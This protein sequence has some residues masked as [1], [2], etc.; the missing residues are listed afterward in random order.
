MARLAVGLLALILALSPSLAAG[1]LPPLIDRDLFFGNPEIS[2]AQLSPDGQFIAFIKPYEG[3][4]NVWVKRLAEPFTAAKLVTTD[5]RRPITNY[6][7]SRDS[8]Y[9][10]F[11]QDKAA[12]R[13]STSTPSIR[14]PRPTRRPASR[15]PRNLTDAK[16][17]RAFIYSLPK[18]KPRRDLRRPERSRSGLARPL[19]GDDLDRRADAAAEEHREDRRLGVRRGRDAA[20]R[21]ARRRQR[22]HRDPPRRRGRLHE[23]LFVQRLRDRA[24]RC[25]STRTAAASTW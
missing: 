15:R 23:G 25:A 12:T 2:G 9:M 5:P 16:G 19:P 4:R 8:K 10:L 17:A 3:T 24:A 18:T 7:W 22:R 6:F 20:P 13:T 14:R 1:Q 21:R 11:A